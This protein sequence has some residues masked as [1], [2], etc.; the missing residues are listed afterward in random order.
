MISNYLKTA[1]RN[2][3]RNKL[4][5][6]LNIF[7][8]AL[9]MATAILILFW[10]QDELSYD[11]YN[12]NHKNIYRV[13]QDFNS[14]NR[15]QERM[16]ITTSSMGHTM[17]TDY[18][19]VNNYCRL[20]R[21]ISATININGTHFIEENLGY[22]D[23]TFFNFFSVPL[24]YGNNND[25]L[26]Q[27]NL[28]A[29]NQT[30][31][32]KY[33]GDKNPIGQHITIRNRTYMIS[34]VYQDIPKNSHFHFNGLMSMI[35]LPE[36]QVT[37][38]DKSSFNTY[39]SLDPGTD[40]NQL[41][42][43]MQSLIRQFMWPIK[44]KY[45][46]GTVDDFIAG[47]SAYKLQPLTDIHLKSDLMFEIEPNGDI[48]Y[49]Y[50]FSFIALFILAIACINFMNMSTAKSE[51][52]SKEVGIRKVSGAS[53]QQIIGQYLL[54]SFLISFIAYFVAMILIELALPWFNNFSGKSIR[55][56]YFDLQTH[57]IL[58][59]LV[60]ISGLTSGSY[61]SIHLSSVKPILALKG[62][63]VFGMKG[64]HL[65]NLLVTLQLITTIVLISCSLIIFK[66]LNYIDNKALGF[67]RKN[68]ICL[69]NAGYLG[70]KSE[71]FKKEM[72]AHP[73][74]IDGTISSFLP[75]PSATYDAGVMPDGDQ[76]KSMNMPHWGIDYDYFKTL[77]LQIIE[78]RAFSSEFGTDSNAVILNQ[79]AINSFGWT[80][81]LNHYIS[82]GAVRNGIFGLN[83][84]KI[85]GVVQDFHFES[86]QK[87]IAPI[88]LYLNGRG[89]M[90]SFRYKTDDVNKVIHLLESK[91]KEFVPNQPF[92]YSFLDERFDN[93]YFSE[94]RISR[95]MI[96]FTILAI[97]IA[98]LGLFGLSAF[99]AE[100]RT[101]EMGI[102]K[103]NGATAFNIFLLFSK[104]IFKLILISFVIAVPPTWYFMNNWLNNFAY[105]INISWTNFLI[106]GFIAFLIAMITISYQAYLSAVRKPVDSL[107]YE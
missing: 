13:I 8:L 16:A 70:E 37:D 90:I 65:R 71:L 75:V 78:G 24:I 83:N 98:A 56:D 50:I 61:P 52:R 99:M 104:N 18:P 45:Y 19:E 87:N 4:F 51:G 17:L 34:G 94:Q 74:F 42:Q 76:K 88:L 2:L 47:G 12:N 26:N 103:V 79:S 60:F 6:F 23:S 3:L 69:H 107:K 43:K 49:I 96:I 32:K 81:P 20:T 29:L 100:K 31:A 86:L 101:K 46:S 38:W 28:I 48:R 7:G 58:F 27:P 80:D 64:M 59:G 102:R 44:G 63:N 53:K 68:I 41:Q 67:N 55:I 22:A 106:S 77:E 97:M 92:A 10:V 5:S 30:T 40:L 95:L 35:T 9:G 25:I 36:S 93:M 39:V 84:F 15:G 91:W 33:F 89:N 14:S 73:E 62:R 57:A 66:Q 85:I 82:R 54:E 11:K 21:R 105:R 1:F 72:L